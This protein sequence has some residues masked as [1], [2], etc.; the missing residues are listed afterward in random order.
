MSEAGRRRRGRT[1]RVVLLGVVAVA[2]AAG[3]V[4]LG[5]WQ[6]D[7]LEWRRARNARVLERTQ[8]PP[9][10]LA[11]LQGQD[12]SLIHW[13]RVRVRGVA[14]YA[15]EALHA[16]RSQNGS[17]GVHLLTPLRP[18]DG[19]WGDT[20]VLLLRGFVMSPDGRTIDKD[21]AR[22]SDT[23]DVDALVTNFPPRRPGNVRMPSAAGAVRLLDRDTLATMM[24]RPLA[25]FVLLA[26]GDTVVRDVTRPARVP[27]PSQ[28]EGAHF[29]YAMQWFG[30]ALVAIVGLVAFARKE[31]GARGDSRN[32]EEL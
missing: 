17:P 24:S 9:L 10:S 19:S 23:I 18:L 6:L 27:P 13:R 12:T 31:R 28:S 15:A 25:P 16:T 2:A 26:L 1:L 5:I 3:C 32:S 4:R 22:E 29:S 30:F 8:A 7:R 11:A 21:E 20:A 14:D